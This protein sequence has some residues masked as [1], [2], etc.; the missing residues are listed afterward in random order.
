M[1]Q[2]QTSSAP[3]AV[4]HLPLSSFF[5]SVEVSGKCHTFTSCC[6]QD[7][8]NVLD[9]LQVSVPLKALSRSSLPMH[10][11]VTIPQH[12]CL[13]LLC[14]RQSLCLAPFHSGHYFPSC[15]TCDPTHHLLGSTT[16]FICFESL[17]SRAHPTVSHAARGCLNGS[18]K[19]AELRTLTLSPPLQSCTCHVLHLTGKRPHLRKRMLPHSLH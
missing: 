14:H 2:N 12:L 8:L 16:T 17:F 13:C 10:Q 1:C 7:T 5:L 6:H 18:Q 3:W 15:L 19:P 4:V 9:H 11:A